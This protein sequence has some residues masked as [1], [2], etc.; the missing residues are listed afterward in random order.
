MKTT[1]MNQDL[2]LAISSLVYFPP[3][4]RFSTQALNETERLSL[5]QN[6]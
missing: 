5:L 2:N 6:V 3:A 1:L 4:S